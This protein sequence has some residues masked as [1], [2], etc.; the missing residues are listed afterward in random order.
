MKPV[1]FDSGPL[2]SLT[3]NNLLWLLEPLSRIYK[4]DFVLPESVRSEVVD[5]PLMTRKFRFEAL[6]VQE[7]VNKG[8]LKVYPDSGTKQ[9]TLELL[10]LANGIFSTRGK[11]LTLVHYGE[12]AAIAASRSLG[13]SALAMDERVT[14]ELIEHPRHLAKI[15]ERKLRSKVVV[16]GEALKSFRSLTGKIRIIRSSELA[17]VAFEKGLLDRYAAP[18][19]GRMKVLESVLWGLKI[20]GCAINERGIRA[21]LAAETGR[22]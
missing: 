1:V 3:S 16:D 7:Y 4:G 10:K 11:T 20:D 8:V 17:A 5:E 2:I 15:M 21:I 22:S 19:A 18:K 12:V 14:R 6:Q 9:E 13:A